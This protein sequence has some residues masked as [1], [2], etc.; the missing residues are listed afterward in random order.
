MSLGESPEYVLFQQLKDLPLVGE[1]SILLQRV[2]DSILIPMLQGICELYDTFLIA[3]KRILLTRTESTRFPSLDVKLVSFFSLARITKLF[4]P[5]EGLN[6][7]VF[8]KGMQF[9]IIESVKEVLYRAVLERCQLN[10]RDAPPSLQLSD[11]DKERNRFIDLNRF[12]GWAFMSIMERCRGLFAINPN[13]SRAKEIFDFLHNQRVLQCE[14]VQEGFL[15]E[16]VHV[17]SRTEQLNKGGSLHSSCSS[18]EVCHQIK[19]QFTDNG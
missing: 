14:T 4:E 18:R 13:N 3:L 9:I 16:S 19:S 8:D 6:H 1:S 10:G 11:E 7:I 5:R 17:D 2:C 12:G 15:K